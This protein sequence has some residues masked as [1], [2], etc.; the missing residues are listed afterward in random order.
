MIGYYP[1]S[2]KYP[3]SII[4]YIYE[5]YEMDGPIGCKRDYTFRVVVQMVSIS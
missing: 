3:Y 5:W 1:D 4:Q 2:I